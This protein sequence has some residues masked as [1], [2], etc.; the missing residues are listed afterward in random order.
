MTLDR[1]PD[2]KRVKFVYSAQFP[3]PT[4]V[5]LDYLLSNEAFTP[6]EGQQ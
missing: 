4:A 3:A 5:V 6:R 1:N 2:A